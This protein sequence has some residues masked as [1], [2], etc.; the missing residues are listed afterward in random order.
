MWGRWGHWVLS[1]QE[2][3]GVQHIQS[4]AAASADAQGLGPTFHIFSRSILIH[5]DCLI[6]HFSILS[7]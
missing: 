1:G 5:F 6:E 7:I 2:A 4:L 3:P